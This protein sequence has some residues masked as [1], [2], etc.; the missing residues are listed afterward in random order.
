[1]LWPL[2]LFG[3]SETVPYFESWSYWTSET[4]I[5]APSKSFV[6]WV[7]ISCGH[8]LGEKRKNVVVYLWNSLIFMRGWWLNPQIPWH[9]IWNRLLA[10]KRRW[11]FDLFQP[12]EFS[13]FSRLGIACSFSVVA[14]FSSELFSAS[15]RSDEVRL[16][17]GKVGAIYRVRKQS[18][19]LYATDVR[20]CRE[21]RL[22]RIV[23]WYV[24][25]VRCVKLIHYSLAPQQ[26]P[27]VLFVWQTCFFYLNTHLNSKYSFD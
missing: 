13:I 4:P 7:L 5:L 15:Q 27:E 1:M 6:F 14:L 19:T 16:C 11:I 26:R 8:I 2:N 12:A 3:F 20:D 21:V 22:P 24:S 18:D 9:A 25:V 17:A 23:Y 10:R